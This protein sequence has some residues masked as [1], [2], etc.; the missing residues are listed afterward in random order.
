MGRSIFC[1]AVEDFANI[2]FHTLPIWDRFW[3]LELESAGVFWIPENWKS[4]LF[5]WK[6]RESDFLLWKKDRHSLFFC[7]VSLKL[8]FIYIPGFRKISIFILT[9]FEWKKTRKWKNSS[10][11]KLFFCNLWCQYQDQGARGIYQI[12]HEFSTGLTPKKERGLFFRFENGEGV[13][14]IFMV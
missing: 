14:S 9:I 6:R 10:V 11:T 2:I 13:W 1:Y 3:I 7:Q 8:E 5:G 4:I 12:L